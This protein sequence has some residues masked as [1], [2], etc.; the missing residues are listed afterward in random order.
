[1]QQYYLPKHQYCPVNVICWTQVHM[2]YNACVFHCLWK[3]N[4]DSL[5]AGIFKTNRYA[6]MKVEF[7][8]RRL[9]KAHTSLNICI[10]WRVFFVYSS[11]S[12]IQYSVKIQNRKITGFTWEVPQYL[13]MLG[14]VYM[15]EFIVDTLV[16][17]MLVSDTSLLLFIKG[18]ID[19]V[20]NSD[21]KL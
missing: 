5:K 13:L 10:A 9:G 11:L 19:K 4:K 8:V 20:V 2:I 6:R 1:M 14:L 15:Q 18:H 12:G 7:M 17:G 3:E 16:I 21:S